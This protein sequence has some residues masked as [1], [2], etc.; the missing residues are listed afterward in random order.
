MGTEQRIRD[1]LAGVL[2]IV[3]IKLYVFNRICNTMLT[4]YL[5]YLIA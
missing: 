5:R 1:T 3:A 4:V 2:R